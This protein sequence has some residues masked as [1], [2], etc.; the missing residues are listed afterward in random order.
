MCTHVCGMYSLPLSTVGQDCVDTRKVWGERTNDVIGGG[1]VWFR[2]KLQLE[3]FRMCRK[4]ILVYDG[5]QDVTQNETRGSR[6]PVRR[7]YS[8]V[9]A[10]DT[11]L[12]TTGR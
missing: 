11:S 9:E 8:S 7:E 10:G 5:T 2:A 1:G 4:R 6:E 12:E 3:R